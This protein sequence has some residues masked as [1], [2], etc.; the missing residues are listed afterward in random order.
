MQNSGSFCSNC[1]Q[2]LESGVSFCSN[3][4]S[5]VNPQIGT[6]NVNPQFR[7][8]P[9][10]STRSVGFLLGVG[11]LF[12]PYIFS[13][14][15]L[16]KGYSNLVR[17]V[18]LGWLGVVVAVLIASPPSSPNNNISN[19]KQGAVSQE[20]TTGSGVP[21]APPPTPMESPRES[22]ARQLKLD[23][24]W[25]K[26]GFGNVMEADFT[27]TNPSDYAVKD[28]EITCTHFASSGTRI[29]SNSRTIYELV[30]AKGKKV[31]RNFNMGFINS[32]S[33]SSNCKI[34]DFELA[35]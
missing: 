34:E 11:I 28:L 14:F 1:G 6:N 16:R 2:R 22:A 30:P 20:S 15:T 27:I 7:G 25:G 26:S 29:D 18:S 4:A 21:Q 8:G 10:G 32:Q 9:Q 5:A 12:M 3:C 31:V 23:F 19:G 24:N 17:V 35:D 33:K 13:W